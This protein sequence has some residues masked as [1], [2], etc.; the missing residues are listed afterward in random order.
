MNRPRACTHR[1]LAVLAGICLLTLVSACGGGR[2]SRPAE[3]SAPAAHAP[4]STA[5]PPARV[6]PAH[7]PLSTATPPARV[8]PA[9]TSDREQ[10]RDE[11]TPET[12][13][14]GRAGA[15]G[16]D[17]FLPAAVPDALGD[18]ALR[19]QGEDGEEGDGRPDGRHSFAL[20]SVGLSDAPKV[21]L[22]V[23]G[24]RF[25]AHTL[26]AAVRTRCGRITI[27]RADPH[28][29]KATILHD[30]HRIILRIGRTV[31]W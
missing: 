19:A 11:Q 18:D 27:I 1:R 28:A 30:G 2:S 14:T 9:H 29:G 24:V 7:A 15:A 4:L 31:W 16:R 10:G 20:L 8:A 13:G 12:G 17:P 25:V 23:A 3:P 21:E 5:T 26:P 6:A 22:A